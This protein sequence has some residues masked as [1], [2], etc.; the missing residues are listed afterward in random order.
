MKKNPKPVVVEKRKA[1]ENNRLNWGARWDFPHLSSNVLWH[2]DTALRPGDELKTIKQAFLLLRPFSSEPERFW[3][4]KAVC[5]VTAS[6]G[7]PGQIT[8]SCSQ[9]VLIS[10]V[11]VS[12]TYGQVAPGLCWCHMHLFRLCTFGFNINKE[13]SFGASKQDCYLLLCVMILYLLLP[14]VPTPAPHPSGL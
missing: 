6:L 11:W 3:D 8:A 13:S 4:W 14:P 12:L 10:R 5:L 2:T 9:H 1:M 7:C